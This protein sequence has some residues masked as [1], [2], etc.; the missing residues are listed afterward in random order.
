MGEVELATAM[1]F[2]LGVFLTVVGVVM[3]AL[4]P[5]LARRSAAERRAAP[6]G[7]S[8]IRFKREAPL[9]GTPAGASAIAPAQGGET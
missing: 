1:A 5:D 7:P 2:D 8:D 4:A 6:E 3:L 9:P